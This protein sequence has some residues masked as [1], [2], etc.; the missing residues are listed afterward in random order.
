MSLKAE[1]FGR[2]PAF[3]PLVQRRLL[4]SPLQQWQ[5]QQ[6]P[7]ESVVKANGCRRPSACVSEAST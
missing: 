4:D 5:P 2:E 7:G 1:K 3:S 6:T